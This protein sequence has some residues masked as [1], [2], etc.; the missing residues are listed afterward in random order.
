MGIGVIPHA[1]GAVFLFQVWQAFNVKCCKRL[2]YKVWNAPPRGSST[3]PPPHIMLCT[4]IVLDKFSLYSKL[5]KCVHQLQP[6]RLSAMWSR[7]SKPF[8]TKSLKASL[9]SDIPFCSFWGRI[10]KTSLVF[11]GNNPFSDDT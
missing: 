10:N 8:Q 9:F 2:S 4:D 11:P 6:E 7:F 3:A 5:S 1:E